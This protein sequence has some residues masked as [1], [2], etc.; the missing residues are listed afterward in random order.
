MT[1]PVDKLPPQPRHLEV[2]KGK[3]PPPASSSTV[4]EVEVEL[5]ACSYLKR[6]SRYLT[7]GSRKRRK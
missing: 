6:C 1:T 5:D 7:W 3:G 2:A 4:Y